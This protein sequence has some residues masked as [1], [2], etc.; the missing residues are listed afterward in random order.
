ME[1]NKKLFWIACFA[2][3]IGAIYWSVISLLQSRSTIFTVFLILN[4][5]VLIINIICLII[6]RKKGK[7]D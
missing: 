3:I 5:A 4:I 2:T 1:Q 7:S 6:D